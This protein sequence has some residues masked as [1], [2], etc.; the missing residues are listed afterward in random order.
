M[1]ELVEDLGNQTQILFIRHLTFQ[2]LFRLW[3]YILREIKVGGL[4]AVSLATLFGIL[5]GM[6][7]QSYV[8]AIILFL[9]LVLSILIAMAMALSIPILLLKIKQDPALAS[10]PFSTA[11]RDIASIVVYFSVA[12]LLLKL[13]T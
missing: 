12:S 7:F 13:L 10:G 4:L 9:T 2:E 1:S 3:P 5:G 8:L 6:L 11:A